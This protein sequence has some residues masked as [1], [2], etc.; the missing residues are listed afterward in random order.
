MEMSLHATENPISS[1]HT[2]KSETITMNAREQYLMEFY[3]F[4]MNNFAFAHHSHCTGLLQ[5]EISYNKD[6]NKLLKRENSTFSL[7]MI[8][9]KT[10]RLSRVGSVLG[11]QKFCERAFDVSSWH[12]VIF[13]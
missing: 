12:F 7:V 6:E 13:L 8:S 11:R 9:S 5:I 3:A 2:K 10:L 4:C 1:Y